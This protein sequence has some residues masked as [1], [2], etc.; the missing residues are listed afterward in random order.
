MRQL[1]GVLPVIY[2]IP[3]IEISTR[4]FSCLPI[5]VS[6]AAMGY[7]APRPCAV[8]LVGLTPPLSALRGTALALS[9]DNTW[10]FMGLPTLSVWPSILTCSSGFC[11][12]M[13]ASRS[14]PT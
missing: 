1:S 9:S 8:I 5:S 13:S 6:L 14:R 11:R 12:S 4:R 7:L 3:I 2:H 10:F